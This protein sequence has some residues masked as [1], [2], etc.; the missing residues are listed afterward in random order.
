MDENTYNALVILTKAM[1]SVLSFGPH[2]DDLLRVQRLDRELSAM[3]AA[4][5]GPHPPPPRSRRGRT[6]DE[7]ED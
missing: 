6:T 4:P 2:G 5:T 7:T 3:T 1:A